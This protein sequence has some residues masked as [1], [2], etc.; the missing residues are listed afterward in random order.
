M[1]LSR[2]RRR[3]LHDLDVGNAQYSGFDQEAEAR[4]G[5]RLNEEMRLAIEDVATN[6]R[7]EETAY[8]RALA[9]DQRL[10]ANVEQTLGVNAHL[11]TEDQNSAARRVMQLEQNDARPAAISLAANPNHRDMYQMTRRI[12]RRI[13]RNFR[14]PQEAIQIVETQLHDRMAAHI[15]A[16]HPHPRAD[17][18]DYTFDI[19]R[20]THNDQEVVTIIARRRIER[21]RNR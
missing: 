6:I 1:R 10:R 15:R 5:G 12:D 13:I 11:N 7:A 3:S 18:W 20:D 9:R 4:E 16:R 14:N 17:D 21:R 19:G 8:Q 2:R